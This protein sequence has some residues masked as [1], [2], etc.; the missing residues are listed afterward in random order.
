M[1][2]AFLSQNWYRIKDL[3]PK[4]RSHTRLY[5]HRY[6]GQ[7]WYVLSDLVTGKS[8]RVSP[9][10]YLFVGRLDG[11]SSVNDIWVEVAEALED[12]A[13]S[14][15]DILGLLAQLDNAGLIQTDVT[16][17]TEEFFERYKKEAKALL[18]QNTMSPMSFRVPLID[19]NRFLD[20]TVG[21]VRWA[22]SGF[23]LMLWLAVVL[24]A[25]FLAGQ[26]WS[27]LTENLSDRVLASQNLLLIACI[28][29]F[30][31]A[32]HE[33][34]HGYVAKAYG[35]EVRE[36]GI[37]FL[38]FFPVPYVDASGAAAFRNKWHRAYVSAAGIIMELLLAA[39]AMYAW[40]NLEP[41]IARAVAY[42]VMVISGFSTVLVNGNP[43]LK[44]DGYYM[45]TDVIESPNLMTRANQY[46]GHLIDHYVF[47]AEM[48]KPYLATPGEK[49]L[50]LLYA[51]AAFVYRMVIMVSIALFVAG[52][53]F[54]VGVL[55]AIWAVLLSLGKPLYTGLKHVLTAPVLR[56]KRQR[57]RWITFG[58]A[59]SLLGLL[60]WLPMPLH[61]ETEGVV[62]LPE[63][64]HVRAQT[65]GFIE[66]T[67]VQAGVRVDKG[68]LLFRLRDPELRLRV[69]SLRW[70]VRELEI[71]LRE[72][73][74]ESP[75]ETKIAQVKLEEERARLRREL[76]R[77]KDLDVIGQRA[78]VFSPVMPVADFDGRFVRK[79]ELIGYLL[80]GESRTVRLLVPQADIELV[81]GSTLDVE[82]M[83]AS[84]THQRGNTEVIREVPAGQYELPSLALAV[85]GGGKFAADPTDPQ[86]RTALNRVFQ[87]DVPLPETLH[88]APFGS[89]VYVRFEHRPE[90]FGFQI[91]RRVRQLFLAQFYA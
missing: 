32:L 40:V 84:D 52:K 38:V 71:E 76:E 14:Q 55:L 3:K 72:K 88:G 44:F 23:G 89:R 74:V 6:R 79:G 27:E 16:P 4:L 81:R 31:K 51:P 85:S 35:A 69:E 78:G 57:A 10:G 53:F 7:P 83:L 77:Q 66:T 17:D 46:L 33:L 28:Y 21:Y 5:R 61:T 87:F 26:H 75:L 63:S 70:K 54:F 73:S 80:P 41:G 9:A 34:W 58:A 45:M 86:G 18:K 8:H 36:I 49:A 82:L 39:F 50:F 29:P 67:F 68:Q 37:M 64:A 2:D 30:V 65:D 43:L 47:G 90:P 1:A 25:V 60:A 22:V 19:P 91:Y 56:L 59:G 24:P 48:S 62:W 13:P 15:D 11:E 42:N 20:R 12:E